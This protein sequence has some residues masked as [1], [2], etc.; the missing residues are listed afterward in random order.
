[1]IDF[2]VAAFSK[3]EEEKVYRAYLTDALMAISHNTA[4]FAAE[5]QVMTQRFAELA[6]WVEVDTR[7][8]DEIAADVIRRAGLKYGR[9]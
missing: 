1:M 9:I 6:G 3:D 7:T 5:G 2:C 4:G 8:G